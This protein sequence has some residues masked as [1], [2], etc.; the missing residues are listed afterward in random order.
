MVK[1]IWKKLA[2]LLL[3]TGCSLP[4][5]FKSSP[6]INFQQGIRPSLPSGYCY[7]N[8]QDPREAKVLYK[9]RQLYGYSEKFS[10]LVF[11]PCPELD[12]LRR[13]DKE[14]KLTHYGL[15]VELARP[16]RIKNP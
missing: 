12:A 15:F 7:L 10:F 5:F 6:P 13:L 9:I 11:L 8:E 1:K 4:S 14:A 2:F 16:A 3:L